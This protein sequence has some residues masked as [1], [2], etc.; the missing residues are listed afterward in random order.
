[1]SFGII[2]IVIIVIAVLFGLIGLIRGFRRTV[3]GLFASLVALAGAIVL[4]GVI[5]N[6]IIDGTTWDE[7]LATLLAGELSP[8][9]TFGGAILE[10]QLSPTGDSQILGF[11]DGKVWHPFADMLEGT[12]FGSNILSGWITNLTANFY[13][14]DAAAAQM[15]FPMI[16][17]TIIVKYSFNVLFFILSYVVLMIFVVILNRLFKRIA[18]GT[19]VGH[20]LDKLLGL[21][22]GVALAWVIVMI[23]LTVLQMLSGFGFMAS[24]NEML[25]NSMLGPYLVEYNFLY[26]LLDSMWGI[27]AIGDKIG[28]LGL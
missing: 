22:L 4:A 26:K 5:T 19:Y 17:G 13:P 7:S 2:D 8:N 3:F 1:M 6:L 16:L 21:V 9:F 12:V 24:V 20:F 15:T 18:A 23:I 10:Y 27:G 11:Y 14:Y 28:G 25:N